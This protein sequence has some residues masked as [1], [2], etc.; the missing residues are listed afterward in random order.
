MKKLLCLGMLL[1][2]GVV[3]AAPWQY[4]IHAYDIKGAPYTGKAY[5]NEMV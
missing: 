1:F 3:M 2:N 4:G 5:V